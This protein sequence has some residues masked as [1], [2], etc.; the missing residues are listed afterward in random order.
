MINSDSDDIT[1]QKTYLTLLINA[2]EQSPSR[3]ANSHSASQI[4]RFVWNPKVL[5][6]VYKNPRLVHI[7]SH[8]NSLHIL[9]LVSLT[10]ILLLS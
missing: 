7:L 3:D 10:S 1:Q 8:V 2:M 6:R 5:H 9:K 4:P